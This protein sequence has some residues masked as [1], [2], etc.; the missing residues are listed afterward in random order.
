MPHAV[1]ELSKRQRLVWTPQLHN[2]FVDAVERLGI[3]AAMLKAIMTIMNVAGLIR[4]NVASHLQKYRLAS[5]RSKNVSH[6]NKVGSIKSSKQGKK[7]GGRSGKVEQ[8]SDQ[9]SESTDDSAAI[10]SDSKKRHSISHL[11]YNSKS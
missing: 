9:L 7:R 8:A 6:G 4:E 10:H 1:G 2:H 11:L 3:D 5:N